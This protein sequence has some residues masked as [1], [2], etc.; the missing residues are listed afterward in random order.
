MPT[1]EYYSSYPYL[2]YK[3]E[4]NFELHLPFYKKDNILYLST[5]S[6]KLVEKGILAAEIA[7]YFFTTYYV[8]KYLYK[9][10]NIRS[11][12]ILFNVI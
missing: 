9:F 5:S 2:I 3:D 1:P 7:L 8:L 6:E 4:F 10:H 12:F 11:I